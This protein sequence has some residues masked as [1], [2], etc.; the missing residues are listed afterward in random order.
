MIR[1]ASPNMASAHF[2]H[3]M[4]CYLNGAISIE[5]EKCMNKINNNTTVTHIDSLFYSIYFICLEKNSVYLE[6]IHLLISL[7][8]YFFFFFIIINAY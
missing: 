2:A 8:C 6:K 7:S 3:S 4:K 1:A 5:N